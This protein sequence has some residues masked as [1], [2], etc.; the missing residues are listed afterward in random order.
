MQT[1]QPGTVLTMLWTPNEPDVP[2]EIAPPPRLLPAVRDMYL[3]DEATRVEYLRSM[4]RK[5]PCPIAQTWL[6]CLL[7]VNLR[8]AR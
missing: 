5:E 1:G 2:R 3:S 8:A 4:I 7:G 6:D